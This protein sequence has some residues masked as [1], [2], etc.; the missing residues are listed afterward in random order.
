MRKLL[1]A[2]Q[3]QKPSCPRVEPVHRLI[4][5]RGPDVVEHEMKAVSGC[6]MP[7]IS[8][9][10]SRKL[11]LA[12]KSGV[13]QHARS[14]AGF[15][16]IGGRP[17]RKVFGLSLLCLLVAGC[18]SRRGQSPIPSPDGSM[19][20]HTRVNQSRD[21]PGAYLC[22]IFEIRDRSGRVL[23]SENTRASDLMRWDMAWLSDDRVRLKS[24][25]VGTSFW[26]KQPDGVWVKEQAQKPPVDGPN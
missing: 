24:S 12:G 17:M 3:V 7:G 14:G 8:A 9:Q 20:L 25:D 18:A 13:K 15:L 19:T 6:Q 4:N 22:I 16:L 21:D 11:E 5:K 23:H 2:Q 1:R 26:R 10:W